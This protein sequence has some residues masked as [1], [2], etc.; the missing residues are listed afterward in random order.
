MDIKI[1]R[2][3]NL[4]GSKEKYNNR[5]VKGNIS[6]S[7]PKIKIDDTEISIIFD[8]VKNY[9][10]IMKDCTRVYREIDQ[11][12]N[13]KKWV[14]YKKV[15]EIDPIKTFKLVNLENNYK[16]YNC[17]VCSLDLSFSD[18]GF[19]KTT[20][21]FE[22]K[23][24]KKNIEKY[25]E[26]MKDSI[27]YYKD[28]RQK[29]GKKGWVDCG[30]KKIQNKTND[31][32]KKFK[33]VN[34]TDKKEKYNGYIVKAC[35]S[36]SGGKGGRFKIQVDN[37]EI[38]ITKKNIENYGK[39]MKDSVRT[40]NG[41]KQIFNERW[42]K[43]IEDDIE[44]ETDDIKTFKLIDVGK[45]SD[46]I[47]RHNLSYPDPSGCFRITVNKN[48]N[49]IIKKS[50]IE[51]FDNIMKD[52]IRI[53]K[54]FREIFKNG[55]WRPICIE[56]ELEPNFN[57]LNEKKGKYCNKHKE[58]D[59]VN[60]KAK[61]CIECSKIKKNT[62][63]SFNYPNKKGGIYCVEHKKDNMID[64]ISGDPI[65]C[66]EH[67]KTSCKECNHRY[68]KHGKYKYKCPV[69]GNASICEHNR[70][71]YGCK[72][73]GGGAYCDHGI[74]YNR[75]RE[76]GTHDGLCKGLCG[77][78]GNP[79]YDYYCTQCFFMKFPDDP[80][81]EDMQKVPTYEDVKKV[82]ESKG[83]EL[84]E[85]TYKDNNVKM[86]NKCKKKGHVNYTKYRVAMT[87]LGC[88]SCR[89]KNESRCR[90]IMEKLF[91]FYFPK[92]RPTFLDY[93]ELDGYAK[94][95]GIAFEYDGEQHYKY[96]PHFHRNGIEDFHA[97]I[98]RDLRKRKLC[99]ENSIH[100]LTI[101]Y[102]IKYKDLENFIH[103]EMEKVLG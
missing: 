103:T 73:C 18:H 38:Y 62:Q 29:F 51:D 50:N 101:P 69:C 42:R 28:R 11:K 2:L 60:V 53:N 102:T 82:F 46:K 99:K 56:C 20:D 68:C 61:N 40:Y 17:K 81:I 8:N 63:P 33:L 91:N 22:I 45:H 9:S 76:C 87:L 47:I 89:Y 21:D 94:D 80:R 79:K 3:I 54:E 27:R 77:K 32:I 1:F 65:L 14:K 41:E 37:N 86:K 90:K 4:T 16:K 57:F 55:R 67:R 83:L 95:I 96:I 78:C 39:I 59:M 49:I 25:D 52:S 31:D 7:N 71:R 75:C 70:Y 100:L 93:L 35:I 97:Q 84:L 12:Y 88:P 34:L 19:F 13:G 66:T 36:F 15:P 48:E 43:F 44:F 10:K 58:K 92:L 24:T 26:I 98:E 64:V 6:F 74:H 30:N 5:I 23:F 85:K 72:D